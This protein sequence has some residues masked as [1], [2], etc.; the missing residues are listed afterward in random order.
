MTFKLQLIS[1][2]DIFKNA[3]DSIE[4]IVDEVTLTADSEALHLRCLSRDHITFITMDL[5][6]TVF[7]EY[8]CDKPEKMAI[9]CT[10]FMKVLKKAKKD[11]T[12]ELET[13]EGNLIITFKGDATRQFKLRFIDMEYDN[14]Q[15]P[16]IAVP[17]NIPIASNLIKDYINDM[18]LYDEKL[19][20]IVDE[21]YL[22]ILATGQI[23][24]GEI[25]YLHG[26]NMN[27]VV[28]S[29]FSIPKLKEIFRASKFSKECILGIGED[30]PIIV[31]FNLPTRDGK[32]EYLLAPRLEQDE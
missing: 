10:E 23:G 19:T 14:P 4:K 13:D 5:E 2:S 22:K 17:C 29:T 25:K 7:D 31:T 20:F 11:D 27:E 30:M 16:Q 6:K 21:D 32:L 1:G 24:D 9:D 8:L 12:L 15:P 28:R 18:D 26:E 3:F